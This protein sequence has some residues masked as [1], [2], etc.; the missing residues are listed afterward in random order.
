MRLLDR[1]VVCLYV[2]LA[3]LPVIAMLRGWRDHRLDG[4]VPAPPRPALALAAVRS[5]DY[6]GK[7]AAWFDVAHGLRSWEI[8]IDNTMLYH[9]FGDTRFGSHVVVGGDGVAFEQD[10]ISY[11]NKS[12]T[13]L[14]ADGAFDALAGRIAA[15][16]RRLARDHRA[17]VP[18]F[19]PSKTTIYPDAVP[20]EWTRALGSPRPSTE[21]V[22]LAMKRALDAHGVAYV[23]GI[24]LLQARPEPRDVLWGPS[25]RH[26]SEYAACL[27]TREVVGR[28]AELTGRPAFDY[29]CQV[30][31]QKAD[32]RQRDLDLFRLLNAWR[33]RHDMIQ[34]ASRHDP[35]PA[36]LPADRPDG[37]PSALWIAS[38]FGWVTMDD[39]A[40]SRRF[41]Q[42]HLDYYHSSVHPQGSYWQFNAAQRDAT[43]RSVFLTRDVYIL[44]LLETY[45]EPGY[46]GAAAI[47]AI[48]AELGP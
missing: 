26:F 40:A 43:W 34:R 28:Y 30:A 41:G 16:Q 32:R 7:F 5:E 21:R 3:A 39:A 23:D 17:L 20:A 24:A 44:E 33:T 22:Y 42:L 38:S 46:F 10:D 25:A 35:L 12:G 36:P 37:A 14:P 27:C 1:L 4:A 13:E 29:P 19:V 31:L 15:L 45:L 8:W 48:S 18:M 47:D 2:A 6:Q 9:A 11:F